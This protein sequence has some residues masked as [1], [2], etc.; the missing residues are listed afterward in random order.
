MSEKPGS[1]YW[2]AQ[3]TAGSF[4]E[5]RYEGQKKNKMDGKKKGS[6]CCSRARVRLSVR[7]QSKTLVRSKLRT[8]SANFKNAPESSR[9]AHFG[10]ALSTLSLK[11]GVS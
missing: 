1:G 8:G 4:A 11:C 9:S 3:S 6:N 5:S 2:Q 7:S 10:R